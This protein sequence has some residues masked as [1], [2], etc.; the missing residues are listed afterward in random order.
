MS[1]TIQLLVVADGDPI[2]QA[3][4]SMLEL[5]DN[6]NIIAEVNGIADVLNRLEVLTPDIVLMD[7]SE[8]QSDPVPWIERMVARFPQTA[9]V[10]L[11]SD[12]DA[13]QVRRYMR[14]GAKDYLFK[15][16]S[17][18]ALCSA[19][20]AVYQS[21]CQRRTRTTVSLL[22]ERS[23]QR[24]C[25]AAFMS[26]KGGVGKTTMAVNTAAAL[27]RQGKR[28]ALVDLDLQFG[29]ASLLLNL[30]PDK[31]IVDL[32]R[33]VQEIDPEVIE[34]YMTVHESGMLLLPADSRPERAEYVTGT[35]IR[36]ILQAL[37]K[38]FEYVI[39]DTAPIA[40]DIFF[41]VLE[42]TDEQFMISTLNLAVLKNNRLLLELLAELD[43]DVRTVK[44]V[45]NRINSKNGLK[46]RDVSKL[47]KADVYWE[48]DNDFNFVETA[49]NEG[50]LF[51][52]KNPQHRLSKQI[53]ALTARLDT[54]RGGRVSRRNPLRKN[55]I[56]RSTS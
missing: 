43:Y 53:Y 44:H 33:E 2:L 52:V 12:S 36:V 14:G 51:I 16:I 18:D 55:W 46:V 32:V 8:T 1:D 48:L 39:V 45:I 7:V 31:S 13:Q 42:T 5:K 10:V 9:I 29:D 27:A 34:R 11:A 15:P 30:V 22:R 23:T 20:F 24:C 41:A 56:G 4:G 54:E 28:T 6:M 25:T 49:A 3:L 40:N 21:E 35:H 17:G 47:L 37:R 26:A 50:N 38:R 19:L